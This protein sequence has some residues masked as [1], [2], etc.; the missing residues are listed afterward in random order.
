MNHLESIWKHRE[1]SYNS[2]SRSFA[3]PDGVKADDIKAAYSDGILKI[4]LP[5]TEIE[6]KKSS[7]KEVKIS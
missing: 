2:F 7:A 3:L 6:K 4:S 5:K 1:Y